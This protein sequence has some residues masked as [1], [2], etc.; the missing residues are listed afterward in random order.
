MTT[1]LVATQIG[2]MSLAAGL[3]LGLSAIALFGGGL[4]AGGIASSGVAFVATLHSRRRKILEPTLQAFVT[5]ASIVPLAAI[6]GLLL[7]TTRLASEAPSILTAYGI[8][9]IAGALSFMI[10]GMLGKIVPFLVW[11]KAYGPKVGREIVPVA[12]SL[13]SKALERAW[14]IAQSIGVPLA[15]AAVWSGSQVLA[16]IAAWVLT[17]GGSIYMWNLGRVARHL[18]R[19][20]RPVPPNG[21]FQT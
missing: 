11:M 16:Q 13:S 19:R 9:I 2:L 21:I 12:T 1:G 6:I 4:L 7:L 10:L 17:V 18:W 15:L 20:E 8:V 14:L 5:G 3:S